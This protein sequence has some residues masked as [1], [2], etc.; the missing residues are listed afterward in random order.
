VV[1]RL[2]EYEVL[3]VTVASD[4]GEMTSVGGVIVIEIVAGAEVPSAL[5]A[6]YVKLSVPM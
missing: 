4:D 2:T 1:P 6:L 3:I 5:L